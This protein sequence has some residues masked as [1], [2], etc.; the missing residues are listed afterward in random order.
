MTK[1]T[2][3]VKFGPG[4]LFIQTP[5]GSHPNSGQWFWIYPTGGTAVEFADGA[6]VAGPEKGFDS[7]ED[8]TIT[9]NLMIGSAASPLVQ[10]L[11]AL[12]I[13]E[14]ELVDPYHPTP[15]DPIPAGEGDA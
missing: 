6:M 5:N 1:H 9:F 15:V 2:I 14:E 11:V 10:N 4:T 7:F 3:K 12:C 8:A 13:E